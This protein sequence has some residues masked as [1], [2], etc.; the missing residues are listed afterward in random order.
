MVLLIVHLPST[1][2]MCFCVTE[3]GLTLSA[4]V[5]A[6]IAGLGTFLLISI[7]VIAEL[8]TNCRVK[9][10]VQQARK[11]QGEQDAVMVAP[12]REV[13]GM[14]TE[15]WCCIISES[16]CLRYDA[17][18]S[19]LNTRC[20]CWY[21]MIDHCTVNFAFFFMSAYFHCCEYLFSML[22][23]VVFTIRYASIVL[24]FCKFLTVSKL[25]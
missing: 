14:M 6:S 25:V 16:S 20:S 7:C 19:S 1:N 12:S 15:I 23:V 3:S 17:Y 10:R 8:I 22:N 18:M 13:S 5:K 21:C 4:T 11:S 9:K 24:Y 2:L